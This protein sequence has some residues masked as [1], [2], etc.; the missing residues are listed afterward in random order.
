MQFSEK[1]NQVSI[2]NLSIVMTNNM[3]ISFQEESSN[4]FNPVKDRLWKHYKRFKVLGP[5][6]LL[7]PCLMW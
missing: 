3:L 4:L 2:D 7:L 6:I 1:L 5:I